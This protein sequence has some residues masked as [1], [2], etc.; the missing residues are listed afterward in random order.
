MAGLAWMI[1]AN[2]AVLLAA[3]TAVRRCGTGRPAA[4]LVLFLL[5]RFAFIMALVIA[6]GLAGL[7][8][9][10]GLGLVSAALLAALLA[11]GERLDFPW[12]LDL[13]PGIPR[14]ALVF[15]AIFAARAVFQT[16][17]YV[18]IDGDATSYHLPK[19]AEWARAGHLLV[20]LGND[21]RAWFPSGLELVEAWW[22]IFLHHD[23]LIELAGLEFL[24]L[25]GAA[26]WALAGWL[27][28]GPFGSMVA[29][30]AVATA[31]GLS[32]QAI[33]GLNDGAAAGLVLAGAA[34]VVHRAP[35]ALL[36]FLGG[37][38]A[39]VKPTAVYA[40]PGLLL[41]MFLVRKTP[42]SPNPGSTAWIA[43]GLALALGGFWF[44]RNWVYTGN[45]LYPAFTKFVYD[46]LGRPMQ[47]LGPSPATLIENLKVLVDFR[48]YDGRRPYHPILE[49]SAGWGPAI[50]ACGL[51]TLVWALRASARM[52]TIAV[53]F[54][55]SLASV[56][57]QVVTDRFNLRFI[58]WFP[59]L[60][61]LG[62]GWAVERH[63]RLAIPAAVAL[64]FTLLATTFY[65]HYSA[66]FLNFHCRRDRWTEGA[67]WLLEIFPDSRVGTYGVFGPRSYL[68][69]RPDFHVEVVSI[70]ADSAADLRRELDRHGL[71]T[72]YAFSVHPK[73]PEGG[74]LAEAVRQGWLHRITE[75]GIYRARR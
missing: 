56:L 27:G 45:P 7:L 42:P 63:R 22:V 47:R 64:A 25:A 4:D 30:L 55:V 59:A 3:R 36:I 39:G 48:L 17:I 23:V 75:L 70:R 24:L 52:R 53:A 13:T 37:L 72:L 34:L 9:P 69:Y 66:S 16:L 2:A 1:V 6:T 29:S 62:I 65:S 8:T 71:D 28:L 10:L 19:V 50:V 32:G 43:A 58:L 5:F 21:P 74:I 51:P 44:A 40:L 33:S 31:P 49:F 68:L 35:P 73:S 12:N 18:P 60:P 14:L 67:A 20:D 54:A 57:A 38:A 41:L 11:R 46:H 61:A 15:L 26:T